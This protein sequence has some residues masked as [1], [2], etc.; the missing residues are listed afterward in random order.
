MSHL[1]QRYQHWLWDIL[2]KHTETIEG[3][4]IKYVVVPW[5]LLLGGPESKTRFVNAMCLIHMPTKNLMILISSKEKRDKYIRYTLL[6]EHLEGMAGLE[7][8]ISPYDE[9]WAKAEFGSALREVEKDAPD[10]Y[11]QMMDAIK[12]KKGTD[13]EHFFALIVELALMKKELP[14]KQYLEQLNDALRERF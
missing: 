2:P 5:F 1:V 12:R 10:I 3:H 13:Q 14:R 4:K 11:D 9:A 6:H 7:F 8:P